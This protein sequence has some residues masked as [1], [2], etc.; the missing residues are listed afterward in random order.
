VPAVAVVRGGFHLR[1]R[2]DWRDPTV[3][4]VGRRGAWAGGQLALANVLLAVVLV[5][6]NGVAGGVV[7]WTFAYAFFLLPFSLFAVPV[8]TTMFPSLARFHQGARPSE[9]G[10][11]LGRAVRAT[12]VLLLGA[13]AALVALAWPVVRIAVFGDA[14]DGGL[15]PFAHALVGFAPGLAGYGLV[16]LLTRA[17]YAVDDARTPFVCTAIGTGAGVVVMVVA[18]AWAPRSER[19][20][21]LAVGYG[22]AYL[23]ATVL[24]AVALGRRLGPDR[25]HP[26]GTVVRVGAA[27]GVALVVMTVVNGAIGATTRA[28]AVVAV[29]VAGAVGAAAYAGALRVLTGVPLRHLV[30]ID[31]G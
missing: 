1:P 29:V 2:L 22:A 11:A 13:T 25:P 30:A 14:A 24:L 9:F 3:R 27:A 19:A 12:V 7:T 18:S 10:A 28:T 6:A 8:A 5:L 16:Y 4:T 21:A 23:V 31:D 20:T 17:S 15:A 26:L